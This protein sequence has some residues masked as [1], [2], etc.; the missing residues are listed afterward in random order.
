MSS[1]MRGM[2]AANAEGRHPSTVH[3]ASLFDYSHLS[4]D[5]VRYSEACS[6]LAAEMIRKLPDGPELSAGLRALWEAQN[7][8]VMAGVLKL[9]EDGS[10]QRSMQ[11]T[12]E[13]D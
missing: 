5:L 8:F 2:P 6:D 10:V 12:L 4:G 13:D 7:C 3:L 9:R 11:K 1:K